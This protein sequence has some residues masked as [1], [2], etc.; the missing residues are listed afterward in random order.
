MDLMD[1]SR[2]FLLLCTVNKKEDEER[3]KSQN[4]NDAVIDIDSSQ[5]IKIIFEDLI[6]KIIKQQKIQKIED[7]KNKIKTKKDCSYYCNKCCTI[8]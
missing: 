3:R 5:N 7:K 6:D 4:Y 1:I 2:P 8:L